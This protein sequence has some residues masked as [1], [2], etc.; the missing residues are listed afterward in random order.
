[1]D[2]YSYNLVALVGLITTNLFIVIWIGLVWTGS[3]ASQAAD[4][5]LII[6]VSA[7][8]VVALAQSVISTSVVP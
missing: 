8:F 4:R 5:V 7:L 3:L 2:S 6:A 1:M